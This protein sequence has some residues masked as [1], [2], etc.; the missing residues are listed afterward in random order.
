MNQYRFGWMVTVVV[1]S[2]ICAFEALLIIAEV[3]K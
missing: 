2:I 1:V 3:L